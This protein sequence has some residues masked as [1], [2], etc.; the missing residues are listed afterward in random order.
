MS[1]GLIAGLLIIDWID[2]RHGIE[3]LFGRLALLPR[4]GIYYLLLISIYVS[5]FY[6]STTQ[7]FFYFQF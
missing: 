1:L 3:A 5:L 2:E 6:H 4:W 7:E